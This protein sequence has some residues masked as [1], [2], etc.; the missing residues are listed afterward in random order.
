M[1]GEASS[2]DWNTNQKSIKLV[3]GVINDFPRIKQAGG[4]EFEA[5]SFSK[6]LEATGFHA[7]S[8]IH[9]HMQIHKSEPLCDSVFFISKVEITVYTSQHFAEDPRR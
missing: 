9:T 5:F 3:L 2:M 6:E 7:S 4:K 8:N 1:G